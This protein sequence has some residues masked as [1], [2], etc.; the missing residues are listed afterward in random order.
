M[1]NAYFQSPRSSSDTCRIA[2]APFG[3]NKQATSKHQMHGHPLKSKNL[4]PGTDSLE[5]TMPMHFVGPDIWLCSRQCRRL[6]PISQ[7]E[8]EREREVYL[9]EKAN[10]T[11]GALDDRKNPAGALPII[12]VDDWTYFNLCGCITQRWK[13]GGKGGRLDSIQ[14]QPH[15]PVCFGQRI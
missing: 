1:G 7:R 8:R 15:G 11:E 6:F 5:D 10:T 2:F 13:W 4:P 3:G 12:A 9:R 14:A